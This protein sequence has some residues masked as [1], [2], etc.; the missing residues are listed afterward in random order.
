MIVE[1]GIDAVVVVRSAMR[2]MSMEGVMLRSVM[3]LLRCEIEV[4]R[5]VSRECRWEGAGC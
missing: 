5:V 1:A 3:I 2:M 4:A